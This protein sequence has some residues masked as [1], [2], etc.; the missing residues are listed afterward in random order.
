[1]RTKT[2]FWYNFVM[3]TK[4]EFWY[5]SVFA[6]KANAKTKFWQLLCYAR[7][8]LCL[9]YVPCKANAKTKL[10]K[11]EVFARTLCTLCLPKF[12]F[13]I[14]KLMPKLCYA[15]TKLY[16]NFVLM[17]KLRYTLRTKTKFM[18]KRSFCNV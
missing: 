1:M 2:L 6:N 5:N 3:R 14:T 13:G 15:K 4:T 7:N 11:N 17:Q 16:Q 12:R 9:N 10:C 8:L 18:Q